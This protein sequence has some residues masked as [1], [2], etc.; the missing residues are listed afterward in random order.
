M[1][2]NGLWS[3][4]LIEAGDYPSVNTEVPGL[5][6]TLIGSDEDWNFLMLK[7]SRS[8]LGFRDPRCRISRGKV[9]GG[10]SAI[11]NLL[12]IGGLPED[13][14]EDGFIQWDGSIFRDIFLY[15]EN[16]T[17]AEASYYAHGQKGPIH[18]EDV[19]YNETIKEMLEK[20]YLDVGCKRMPKRHSL[21][22]INHL[23]MRKDGERYSMAKAFL[24]S[25]KD[26]PNL[27]FSKNTV[28][29]SIGISEPVD[30]RATGVN[31]SID[32]VK[33][34]LRAKK[35][36]ILAAG[37]INN[38]KLLLLSGIGEKKYLENLKLPYN[39]YIPAVGKY[40]QMHI[41]LPIYVRING[42]CPGC[43]PEKY[44]EYELY[45]DTF[46]YILFRKG[47]F[48]HT[49]VN[50]F[51]NYILTKKTGTTLPNLSIQHMYFKV[52]DRSLL[53][54]LEA[55]NYQS[56]ITGT[57]LRVNKEKPI[58]LFLVT[59]IHPVSRG[60]VNLNETHLLG[61]P[62]IKGNFFGDEDSWDYDTM[63]SGF[64]F[65]TNFT[66]TVLNAVGGEFIDIDVPNCRNYKFCSMRYVRCYI[67]N[68]AFPRGGIA[69]TTRM[70]PECDE[71]AVV[72]EDLELR[73]VRC[74]RVADSSILREL[75][76]A[77][78]IATDAAIGFRLGEILKAKWMK[79][80]EAKFKVGTEE[81]EE[82]QPQE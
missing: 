42:T 58:I 11:E 45:Q 34:F 36:V 10:T 41:V 18:L 66:S 51:V 14:N 5:Y 7:E 82:E 69:G 47:R 29:E 38:P 68:M 67:E 24:T 56:R 57:L 33:L 39:A 76:R 32:G 20:Y 62:F 40:L 60:E 64:N 27:F 46:D 77:N 72:K 3:V 74:L 49:N 9:L 8:C 75:P 50:N 70:G 4:L 31:V 21:G 52:D 73:R 12:H 19:T 17:G 15:L 1:T 80:Y 48:T 13:Y 22:M 78:T 63:L 6:T 30:K 35:E 61:D 53:A 2:E 81:E 16:Y 65:I 71:T 79:D 25:I 59:L 37:P 43:Q 44:H 23:L 28:A 54:W 26:R 55:M